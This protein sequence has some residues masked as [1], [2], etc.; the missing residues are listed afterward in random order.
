LAVG[1]RNGRGILFALVIFFTAGYL[2]SKARH[3]ADANV[4]ERLFHSNYHLHHWPAGMAVSSLAGMVSGLLG[5]GGGFIKV[6]VMCAIMGAP[7]R[8]ATATSNFGVA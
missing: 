8:V 5:V 4:P 3:R 6:P 7:L 2:L 1:F